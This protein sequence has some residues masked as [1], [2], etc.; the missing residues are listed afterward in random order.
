MLF[1]TF[2]P[3]PYLADFVDNLWL[4]E[5]YQAEHTNERILPSGT[6]ELVVNLH[7]DELRIYKTDDDERCT[8]FSGSVVSG[9]YKS[10]FVSDTKEEA[11]IMGVHFKPGGAF[12]FLGVSA[13]ELADSHV[14]LD[15]LWGRTA[16]GI[17]DRLLE[18]SSPDERFRI[19]QEALMSHISRPL[20]HHYAVSAALRILERH[21]MPIRKLAKEVGLSERRFIQVFR[22]E[23]GMTPKAFSRV[24][25]FQR[26]RIFIER[27]EIPDWPSVAMQFGYFDQSHLIREFREF[28]GA[29]PEAYW[30]QH[31]GLIAGD[32][33]IKTNHLPV[34]E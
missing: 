29:S 16:T 3:S 31:R 18:A 15:L 25:R 11:F 1:R 20:E 13:D 22:S 32:V 33:H 14:D 2:E 6:I 23:I 34:F 8:R 17:R 27:V 21:N 5:G 9:P 26:A 30:R 19:L 7:E 24:Q 12:P 10:G 28:S 4:Y